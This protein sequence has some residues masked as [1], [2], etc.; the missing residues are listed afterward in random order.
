MAKF[1]E[2]MIRPYGLKGILD[3]LLPLLEK[4]DDP[5]LELEFR[6]GFYV[7]ET[8]TQKFNKLSLGKQTSFDTNLPKEHFE[9]IKACLETNPD[10][11]RVNETERTDYRI[12]WK[13]KK[14]KEAKIL[15]VSEENGKKTCMEKVKCCVVDLRFEN[16]PFDL[17]ISFSKEIDRKM[18]IKKE[19][20]D[21]TREKKT[22]QFVHG[23]WSFDLSHVKFTQNNI[24]KTLHEVELEADLK[25]GDSVSHKATPTYILHSGFLKFYDIVNMIEPIPEDAFLKVLNTKEMQTV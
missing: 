12:K 9:Q 25:K 21:G 22:S 6:L 10:W 16:T 13:T 14:M 11:E 7:K 2:Y 23:I 20:L 24:E 3:V 19:K 15:R 17:R 8:L 1:E 5:N 4:Y 18:P